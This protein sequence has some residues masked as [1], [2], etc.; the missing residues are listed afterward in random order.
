MNDRL[1]QV[2]K[3]KYNVEEATFLE[4]LQMQ[5]QKGVRVEEI[6]FQRKL[7]SEIQI[8]EA[9][10][11]AYE[12]PFWPELPLENICTDFTQHFPIQFLK[13]HILV[14]LMIRG[15]GSQNNFSSRPEDERKPYESF[16]I[17]IHGMNHFQPLDDLVRIMGITEYQLVLST[18]N[19]IL[20][21]INMSYHFCR[22][23]AEQLVQ[24]MEVD[25]RTII[26]EIEYTA[27]LLDD[28]SDAPIIN[29][30]N[31]VISQAVKERARATHVEPYQDSF[32]IRYRVDGIL[33]DLL[34]PPKWIQSALISRI[35]VVNKRNFA[36]KR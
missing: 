32:K 17:A 5:R 36:E 34:T 26:S 1:H 20:S 4:A 23:S 14:P 30:V 21:A 6:L 22:D 31:H 25:G 3:E 18:K 7:L 10:S 35:K 13:K 2:L 33:Y 24:D 12:I 11:T 28:T 15:R 8:L 19:A 9:L 27:D 16:V 29:L